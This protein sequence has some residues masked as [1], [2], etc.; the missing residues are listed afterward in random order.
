VFI[1]KEIYEL[2]VMRF[3]VYALELHMR[4]KLHTRSKCKKIEEM[5]LNFLEPNL[6]VD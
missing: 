2:L 3:F 6:S 5:G 1:T 4:S